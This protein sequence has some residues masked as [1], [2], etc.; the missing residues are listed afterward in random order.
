MHVLGGVFFEMQTCDADPDGTFGGRHVEVAAG[1]D[2]GVVLGDL[3][4][5]RQVGVK[6]VLT[7]KHGPGRDFAIQ[8]EPCHH[9][10]LDGLLVD[11][12]Q[13]ARVPE[14]DWAGV[15]V[16]LFTVGDPAGTEHLRLGGEMDVKLEPDDRLVSPLLLYLQVVSPRASLATPY[17]HSSTG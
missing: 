4:P 10:E 1:A 7:R 6:V 17:G 15:G 13:G 14:T 2:G 16:G 5:L 9:P 8:S 11:D 3:I 12:R